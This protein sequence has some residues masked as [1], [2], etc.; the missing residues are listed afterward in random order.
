MN[1][2]KEMLFYAVLPYKWNN[3]FFFSLQTIVDLKSNVR[4][5]TFL[6]LWHKQKTKNKRTKR[7][8][9]DDT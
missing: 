1:C 4:I 3:V 7:M 8:F 2:T 5:L 9:G 6:S